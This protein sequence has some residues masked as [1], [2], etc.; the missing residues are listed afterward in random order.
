MTWQAFI[1]AMSAA[2]AVC[3][4]IIVWAGKIGRMIGEEKVER[5]GIKADIHELKSDFKGVRTE[6]GV[7]QGVASTIAQLLTQQANDGRRID[8]IENRLDHVEDAKA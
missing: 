6:I 8:R 5:D 7:L 2:F 1:P 4:T 3:T